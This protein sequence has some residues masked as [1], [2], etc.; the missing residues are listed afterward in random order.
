MKSRYEHLV[1]LVNENV[2]HANMP[3]NLN[4]KDKKITTLKRWSY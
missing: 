3:I 2:N 1:L 4:V